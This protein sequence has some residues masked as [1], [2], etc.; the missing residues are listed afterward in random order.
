MAEE[1]PVDVPVAAEPVAEAEQPAAADAQLEQPAADAEQ[2]ADAEAGQKRSRD[3][4]A[5]EIDG[6]PEAK[7]LAPADGEASIT[8][9]FM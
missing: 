7:R 8:I 9:T 2:A 6:E 1:A 4:E 5:A 3:D